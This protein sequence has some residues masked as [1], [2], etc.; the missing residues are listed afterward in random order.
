[1]IKPR[2]APEL[3]RWA[4]LFMLL[5]RI[6]YLVA[7]MLLYSNMVAHAQ[8]ESTDR[9]RAFA[10]SAADLI[11]KDQCDSLYEQFAPSI[12]QAYDRKELL[13]SMELVQTM[14][15]KLL[16]HEFRTLSQGWREVS[17]KRIKI[18]QYTYAVAT[19]RYPT[20]R[21]MNIQVTYEDGRFYLAGYSVVQF[22]GT[23]EPSF[24]KPTQ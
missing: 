5:E 8:A 12:R 14:H 4:S 9:V 1:M 19:S 24:L 17:G 3:G 23:K 13:A 18:A 11:L 7:V 20:G 15:G 16:S 10:D 22:I 2:R 21:F 6:S